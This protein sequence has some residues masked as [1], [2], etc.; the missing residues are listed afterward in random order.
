MTR[1]KGFSL[2]ELMIVLAALGGIALLVTKLGKDSMSIKSESLIAN[3]YNDL[4]RE[5]HFVLSNLKYCKVSLGGTSFQSSDRSKPITNLELWT[6]DSLGANRIKKKFAKG[7]TFGAIQIEDVSLMLEPEGRNQNTEEI[8][9]TSAVVKISLAKQKIKNN[10]IDIE[11]SINLTYSK[12]QDGKMTIIDCNANYDS[13]ESAKVWCG[14]IQNPCGSENIQVVAI[15]KYEDGKF[16][17]IFQ[18]NNIVD[19]KIC[20]AAINR[21]A[22]LSS[23][24]SKL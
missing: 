16:T 6:S 5:S 4:V 24:S 21:P 17:G 13:K 7:M 8:Q 20:K 1:N 14:I 19:G 12:G 18:P 22:T 9:A 10:L 11:Q 2:V 3:D 23:C 15:G